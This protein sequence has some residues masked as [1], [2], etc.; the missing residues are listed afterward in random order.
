MKKI[1]TLSLFMSILSATAFANCPTPSSFSFSG[2]YWGASTPDGTLWQIISP[3]SVNDPI[4]EFLGVE[5][6]EDTASHP[7]LPYIIDMEL[8]CFY[9]TNLGMP[10]NAVPVQADQYPFLVLSLSNW[11]IR[12][13][14]SVSISLQCGD[15]FHEMD[16]ANCPFVS[17][18]TLHHK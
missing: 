5:G 8:A 3:G 2:G 11:S 6:G 4:A 9:K 14:S 1:F 13:P 18:W 10:T 7:T 16:T 17:A 12:V 15:S